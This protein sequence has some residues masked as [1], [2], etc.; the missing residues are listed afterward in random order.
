MQRDRSFFPFFLNQFPLSVLFLGLWWL[1]LRRSQPWLSKFTMV[2]NSHPFGS[3]SHPGVR[4]SHASI[5][6]S[7]RFTWALAGLVLSCSQFPGLRSHTHLLSQPSLPI[8]FKNWI[9]SPHSLKCLLQEQWGFCL[10]F[11]VNSWFPLTFSKFI[12]T[13]AS[14]LLWFHLWKT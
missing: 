14:F 11:K 9:H 13:T 6:R 1:S 3:Q 12:K 10:H 5:T 4:Y 7:P 8:F 2:R